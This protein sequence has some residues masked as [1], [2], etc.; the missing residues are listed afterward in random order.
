MSM[1]PDAEDVSRILR[2]LTPQQEKV[3]RLY[4]GL[5]CRRAHSA[6]E[7]AEEFGV[8]PATIAGILGAAK[9]SLAD[10]GINAQDLLEAAGGT[11]VARRTSSHHHRRRRRT[12]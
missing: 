6:A 5:G 7:I 3:V 1:G 12:T 9:K 2:K 11:I 8:S 10:A 4:F